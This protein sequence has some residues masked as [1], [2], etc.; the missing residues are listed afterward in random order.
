MGPGLCPEEGIIEEGKE[1]RTGIIRYLVC[2]KPSFLLDIKS[3]ILKLFCI[4]CFLQ[5]LREIL[6]GSRWHYNGF[7]GN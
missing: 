6:K 7:L 5:V 4:L 2:T 1:E 3:K